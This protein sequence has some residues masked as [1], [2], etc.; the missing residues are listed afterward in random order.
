V[1]QELPEWA[2]AWLEFPAKINVK[3]GTI[4]VWRSMPNSHK[5]LAMRFPPLSVARVRGTD[6]VCVVL[7]AKTL[8]F[9]NDTLDVL[10]LATHSCPEKAVIIAVAPSLCELVGC[11][12]EYTPSVM[13][14]IFAAAG[15]A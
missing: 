15:D 2:T 8:Q 3:A 14:E 7:R 12:G 11:H 4:A 6:V 1:S 9:G 5:A 13:S 10:M